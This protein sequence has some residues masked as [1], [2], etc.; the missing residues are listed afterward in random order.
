MSSLPNELRSYLTIPNEHLLLPISQ[1]QTNPCCY[2]QVPNGPLPQPLNTR[3]PVRDAKWVLPVACHYHR[4]SSWTPRGLLFSPA[5]DSQPCG[6]CTEADGPDQ[7]KAIAA[8]PG[9]HHWAYATDF[10]TVRAQNCRRLSPIKLIRLVNFHSRFVPPTSLGC[11]LAQP[12]TTSN[13][14]PLTTKRLFVV[15]S[16][17]I[18]HL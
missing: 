3:L 15:I 12:T 2:L 9:S 10:G 1:Y 8:I 17:L 11:Y 7:E 4:F 6:K 14:Q 5:T 13:H 18:C 16:I